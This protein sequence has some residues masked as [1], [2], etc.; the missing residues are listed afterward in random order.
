M[1]KDINTSIHVCK[2]EILRCIR[3]IWKSENEEMWHILCR[4]IVRY[5]S[6]ERLKQ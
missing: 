3:D 6:D 2:K 5:T 1:K 4:F